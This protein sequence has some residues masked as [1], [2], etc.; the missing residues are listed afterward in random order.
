MLLSS[1]QLSVLE[2]F[3]G[4]YKGSFTGRYIAR[5]KSLNQKSVA[6]TLNR[7]ENEG[8]LKSTTVG[9]N[10]QF[11]LNLGDLETVKNL[12]LAAE[13]LRTASFLKK[14]PLIKEVFAKTRPVF[15]GIVVV[16]GSYA[17]GTQKKDS[18]L[19]VFVAGTYDRNRV[20]GVS[21]LYNLQISVKNYPSGAFR[22]ALKN[23]DILLNEILK[24]HFIIEGAEEFVNAVLR[25]YYGQD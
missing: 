12:I 19:D 18:D 9:R 6:N 17:K 3:L 13:H 15:H 8:V 14:N 24:S 20:S 16:F 2:E 1:L 22:R 7:L 4:D 5:K 25:D 11:S 10:K 21:E 23:R